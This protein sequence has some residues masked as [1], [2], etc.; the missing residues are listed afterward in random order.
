M[1][2]VVTPPARG[3]LALAMDGGFTYTPTAAYT[4]P[5]SFSYR[6]SD[7]TAFSPTV[8]VS[9]SVELPTALKIWR[10]Q[11]FGSL[12]DAGT[13]ANS[14][15]PAQDG[16]PN[17]IKFATGNGT[18]D[19]KFPGVLPIQSGMNAEGDAF[20]FI[21][22]RNKFAAEAGVTTTVKWSETL[23]PESWSEVGVTLIDNENMGD[24]ERLTMEIPL[25]TGGRRYSTGSGG[26]DRSLGLMEGTRI[27]R[28]PHTHTK[29]R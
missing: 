3:T 13:G 15:T 8:T 27:S 20:Q 9:L 21:Y 23:Q 5:D 2:F 19:P 22:T 14:G 24:T 16:I 25:P 29:I 7:G 11:W 17:L 12:A 4:G 6:T 18:V 26:N 1:A 10:Q 28:R